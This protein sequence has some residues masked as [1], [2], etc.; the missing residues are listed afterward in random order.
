LL[1][2]IFVI[3]LNFVFLLGFEVPHEH[4]D[5]DF[6]LIAELANPSSKYF[7]LPYLSAEKRESLR[8]TITENHKKSIATL[9]RNFSRQLS[10]FSSE[11]VDVRI[12]PFER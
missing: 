2:D 12:P 11:L 4:L 1:F 7:Q 10:R 5:H 8:K 6:N 9:K 3:L